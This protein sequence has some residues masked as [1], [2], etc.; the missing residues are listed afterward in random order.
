MQ[1]GNLMSALCTFALAYT[2]A[3]SMSPSFIMEF[4]LFF[5]FLRGLS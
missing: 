1:V 4:Y 3:V 2:I 5:S